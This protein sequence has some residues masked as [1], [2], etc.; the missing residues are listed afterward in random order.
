[1]RRKKDNPGEPKFTKASAAYKSK[2]HHSLE[3][4]HLEKLDEFK[5]KDK[6]IAQKR[7]QIATLQ[8]EI[9]ELNKHI[10]M[11]SVTGRSS[12]QSSKDEDIVRDKYKFRKNLDAESRKILQHFDKDDDFYIDVNAN[13][14]MHKERELE[15]LQTELRY[16][17]SNQDEVDYLLDTVKILSEYDR[18]QQEEQRVLDMIEKG[19]EHSSGDMFHCPDRATAPSSSTPQP[20]KPPT[21]RNILAFLETDTTEPQETRHEANVPSPDTDQKSESLEKKLFDIVKTK[22]HLVHEYNKVTDSDHALLPQIDALDFLCPRCGLEMA[23]NEGHDVCTDCGYTM[24][25]LQFG[26][27]PSYKELQEYDFKPQFTYMKIT[28]FDDW[29]RRFQAKENTQIPQEIYDKVLLEIKKERITDLSTL[30]EEKVKKYL[31]KLQYNKYYDHIV[32]IIHRLNGI[33]PLK[34]TVEI[35]EKLRQMFLQIQEPF[36]KHKPKSRKNFLSYSY[37]LHKFFQILG[38]PE[39]TKY[40]SLLKSPEKLRQQDEIFKKIVKEMAEKDATVKWVF[41]PSI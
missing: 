10:S 37:V 23:Q 19:G 12:N 21:S 14:K 40:F 26:D 28:H 24:S 16:I 39:Y 22:S 33:P 11:S 7:K 34:L 41:V 27:T 25:S 8:K 32:H 18:L 1:M 31:K 38:L 20:A 36:E 4:R 9:R 13:K 35:E 2:S 15:T 17:E 3:N 29:L 6:L 30:S 5:N